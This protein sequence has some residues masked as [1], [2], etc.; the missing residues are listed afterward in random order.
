MLTYLPERTLE[1]FL[2]KY[3]SCPV[4]TFLKANLPAEVLCQFLSNLLG[5]FFAKSLVS[6]VFIFINDALL[7]CAF[8]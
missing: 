6:P 8:H 1:S 5:S 3:K 7:K 2:S 4:F